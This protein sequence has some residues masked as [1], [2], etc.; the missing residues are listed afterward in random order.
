MAVGRMPQKGKAVDG[1]RQIGVR[2]FRSRADL[3]CDKVQGMT[4]EV[5]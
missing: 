3:G 5:D 1:D 2:D 4:V